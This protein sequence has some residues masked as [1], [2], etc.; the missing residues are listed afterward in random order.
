MAKIA[1]PSN[2]PSCSTNGFTSDSW[3]PSINQSN[4]GCGAS[5]GRKVDDTQCGTTLKITGGST[6]TAPND[7]CYG[8]LDTSK[9]LYNDPSG[10]P[11]NDVKTRYGNPVSGDCLTWVN[12]M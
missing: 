3:I 11:M 10:T 2:Y 12:D 6:A 5:S 8:C 7:G 9:I 1:T 4:V